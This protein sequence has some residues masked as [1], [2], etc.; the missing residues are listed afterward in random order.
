MKASGKKC[1]NKIGISDESKKEAQKP[2]IDQIKKLM[3]ELQ[4]IEENCDDCE[5]I[6]KLREYITVTHCKGHMRI[7]LRILS[8]HHPE[9]VVEEGRDQPDLTASLLFDQYKEE[10]ATVKSRELHDSDVEEPAEKVFVFQANH[11]TEQKISNENFVAIP[12]SLE[13]AISDDELARQESGKQV[14]KEI[15]K[16]EPVDDSAIE[17]VKGMKAAEDAIKFPEKTEADFADFMPNLPRYPG[18]LFGNSRLFFQEQPN[19]HNNAGKDDKSAVEP[20]PDRDEKED[21]KPVLGDEEAT[22]A[23]QNLPDVPKEEPKLVKKEFSE[24]Q[25]LAVAEYPVLTEPTP[26]SAPSF[27]VPIITPKNIATESKDL[28]PITGLDTQ[29][30]AQIEIAPPQEDDVSSLDETSQLSEPSGTEEPPNEL[31]TQADGL[32]ASLAT[33][34]DVPSA[35]SNVTAEDGVDLKVEHPDDDK[36]DVPIEGKVETTDVNCCKPFESATPEVKTAE[37]HQQEPT[38]AN[39]LP[40]GLIKKQEAEP[41][42]ANYAEIVPTE[43]ECAP[44]TPSSADVAESETMELPQPEL[45][46]PMEREKEAHDES[47]EAGDLKEEQTPLAT[48]PFEDEPHEDHKPTAEEAELESTSIGNTDSARFNDEALSLSE[49]YGTITVSGSSNVTYRL[50][51]YNTISAFADDTTASIADDASYH[52]TSE[53]L[54]QINENRPQYLKADTPDTST[55][56]EISSAEPS[57][58]FDDNDISANDSLQSQITPDSSYI[59]APLVTEKPIKRKPVNSP[60][61]RDS[62][63][64]VPS[65]SS[66]SRDIDTNTLDTDASQNI[67][68]PRSSFGGDLAETNHKFLTK[69]GLRKSAS[70]TTD[71]ETKKSSKGKGMLKNANA[72]IVQKTF[73]HIVP[74]RVREADDLLEENLPKDWTTMGHRLEEIYRKEE[75]NYKERA[76]ELKSGSSLVVN[77]TE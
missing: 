3:G 15:V 71:P 63:L 23:I 58:L 19:A 25:A 49:E 41:L 2:K 18:Q 13:D 70:F 57:S 51:D 24:A 66:L 27:G 68:K 72:K 75:K 45:M 52:F 46:A 30:I 67:A 40:A 69:V 54:G 7:N 62:L 4:N 33:K 43:V 73:K 36:E 44:S 76:A 77:R 21:V 37:E 8:E 39:A 29:P 55:L 26:S 22:L 16:K 61:N 9:K 12:V 56:E 50:D 1:G 10:S 64:E 53:E 60:P 31:D 42:E 48:A 20:K 47:S 74:D 35:P 11:S 65:I 28:K 14:K 32:G 5:C 34:E 17:S 59:Q 38:V 6:S